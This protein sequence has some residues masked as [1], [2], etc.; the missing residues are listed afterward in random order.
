[1]VLA[2]AACWIARR[3]VKPLEELS[4]HAEWFAPRDLRHRVPA[5]TSEE[6]GGLGETLNKMAAELD[7]KL[8]TV[9]RRRTSATRSLQHGRGRVGHRRRGAVLS[10]NERR[11]AFGGRRRQG[12]RPA[13][14]PEIVRSIELQKLV[15]AVLSSRQ[16]VEGEVALRDRTPRFLR[17]HG[18]LLHNPP[19]G[20]SRRLAG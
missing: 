6:I 3:D 5:G 7:D 12:R 8:A 19:D 13:R 16:P 17:V 1:V 11:A 10:M 9:V 4:P 2:V 15:A 14:W 18:T 20:P